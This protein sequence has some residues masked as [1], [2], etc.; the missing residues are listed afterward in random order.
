MIFDAVP[1]VLSRY[2]LSL[3]LFLLVTVCAGEFAHAAPLSTGTPNLPGSPANDAPVMIEADR[4]SY[5]NPN[6]TVIA[7]GDVEIMQGERILRADR[8]TY[9]KKTDTVYANG[10]VSVLEPDGNIY[11][12]EKVEL[13][14]RFKK[15][16]IDQFRARLSDQSLF[17]ASEARR[18]SETRV[19]M[20][21]AVYSPCHICLSDDGSPNPP[22]WQI[23]AGEMKVDEEEQKVTYADARLEVLG[24]PVAYSPYLSHPTPG[25]DNKSGFLAPT[26]SNSSQLGTTLQIPYFFAIAPNM[27]ATLAPMFT[28]Q[29]GNVARGEFRHKVEEGTYAL[30]GSIT[31]PRRRGSQG[32]RIE[33]N[34]ERWHVEGNGAF[35]LN[36]VW[37]AGFNARRASDDTYMRR[38][39]FSYDNVLT[40]R[41]YLEG[42]GRGEHQR[43]YGNLETISFQGL[44]ATDD[45]RTTP[46]ILPMASGS[47][48]VMMP[49][50]N[51]RVKFSGNA[52]S[53]TRDLGSSTRRL[54][55]TGEWITPFETTGGHLFELSGSLR[56]D[57]YHIENVST[58]A[59]RSSESV[60]RFHPQAAADWRFPLVRQDEGRKIILEP[61]V[62]AIASSKSNN[63]SI[64]PNEDSQIAELSASNLFD[65]NRQTGLDR[66][67]T[68]HRVQYGL[69]TGVQWQREMVANM[70]FG[71]EY[72]ASAKNGEK[73]FSDYVGGVE[74]SNPWLF[75]S[76]RFRL[77]QR[78]FSTESNEIST[79]LTL[80]KVRFNADFI[81]LKDAITLQDRRE[82]FA[83]AS[84]QL[85]EHWTLTS[86]GRRNLRDDGG[87]IS[88][89]V[90][91]NY[92]NECITV[93]TSMRRDFIRDRD[94]EPSTSYLVQLLLRNVN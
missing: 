4:L 49:F 7:E 47:H 65:R 82:I 54:S 10:N 20:K 3:A 45:T 61:R 16:V 73:D 18:I 33:G 92:Q 17:A 14:D 62:Q 38:Y 81:S 12:A 22:L 91:L 23:K 78:D 80:G 39:G 42:L 59:S 55:A 50:A 67:D 41:A 51:S 28:S 30:A 85:Q 60:N 66:L 74:V 35:A 69:R 93:L 77:N 58:P 52:L 1:L 32:E 76:Y 25:A 26:Y 75:M 9:A 29:E 24:V 44:R 87:W 89:S 43:S 90:G 5:D 31:N 27:D 46:L 40:S 64:I 13:T 83:G 6:E 15:G 57:M 36:D 68:G 88:T 48:E 19:E 53:L 11:F 70:L 79:A 56:N 84:Y 94:I 8:L 63:S 71:Q 21:R 72:V 86:S 34:E 2:L 37:G